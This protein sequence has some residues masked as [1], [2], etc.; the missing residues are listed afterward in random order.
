M[1][2]LLC[3]LLILPLAVS[4][5]TFEQ[6]YEGI[7]NLNLTTGS[8]DIIVK[9]S[10]GS[11][12]TLMLEH[13]FGDSYNPS[14]DQR[15]DRLIIKDG[16][17]RGNS[18]DQTYTLMVPD[19]TNINFTTGSGNISASGLTVD[20][21]GNTGSGDLEFTQMKGEVSINAGSGD[22]NVSEYDGNLKLNVGSGDATIDG[23]KGDLTINCGS[24]DLEAENIAAEIHI[25]AGSGSLELEN[26]TFTGKSA[27]NAGS[28][29]VNV[30]L[31]AS[32][33]HDLAINAGSGK[34]NL[35]MNGNSFGGILVLE[36]EKKKGKIDAPYTF[37]KT[38]E[39]KEN[40]QTKIRKT[41]KMGN[42]S[43]KIKIATG[44]GVASVEK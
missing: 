39:I 34:A 42:E 20:L 1:R 44:S 36:A 8:G 19:N 40:G 30:S 14:I 17:N 22:L 4:A 31:G 3:F 2:L 12:V 37:D 26:T 7:K 41:V 28:G 38:E 35:D 43:V 29:T 5:Q 24:G 11:Q 10:S 13:S 9:K 6:S 16:K 18:G 32:L 23:Y 27:L 21:N 25:N 15:G 33:K